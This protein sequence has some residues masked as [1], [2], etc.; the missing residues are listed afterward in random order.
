MLAIN[1]IY[2]KKHF[3]FKFYKTFRETIFK[4]HN[5]D[6]LKVSFSLFFSKT[7]GIRVCIFFQ[8]L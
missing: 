4:R 2:Y 5:L 1:N 8:H 3:P 7:K 6:Y